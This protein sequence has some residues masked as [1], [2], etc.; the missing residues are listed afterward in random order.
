MEFAQFS[1]LLDLTRIVDHLFKDEEH[2][3]RVVNLTDWLQDALKHG[4]FSSYFVGKAWLKAFGW[5]WEGEIPTMPRYVLLAAPHTSNWDLPFMLAISFVMQVRL[6]WMGKQSLFKG[7][8]GRFLKALG[9]IEI[10]R[11]K[12]HN[13]VDQ[14][15]ELM[16]SVDQ[17]ILVVA[18]EGTRKGV[19][20]WK[21][22][23]YYIALKADVPIACGFLDYDRK[24][25]GI[26]PVFKP[27]GDI[28]ADM[29]RIREFYADK[30][31]M[32]KEKFNIDFDYKKPEREPESVS[33]K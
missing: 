9:G 29:E 8:G 7:L 3:Y 24:V 15:A 33:G 31:A 12:S 18:P 23:F 30:G 11:S 26:G 19:D 21:T 22:G 5:R 14:I 6:Q 1:P 13:Y 2:G 32:Y 16:H 4:P 25:G 28:E 10:D 17:F 20:R 27:T